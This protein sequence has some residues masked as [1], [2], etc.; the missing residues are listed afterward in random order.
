MSQHCT[1]ASA[2]DKRVEELVL[3]GKKIIHIYRY[4]DILLQDLAFTLSM[5]LQTLVAA[6]MGSA[7]DEEN[8]NLFS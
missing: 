8:R 3:K 4:V 6:F 2:F 1:E 5:Q 7:E